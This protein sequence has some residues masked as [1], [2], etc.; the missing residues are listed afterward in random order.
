M[1]RQ[2]QIEKAALTFTCGYCDAAEGEPCRSKT[3]KVRVY[4]H[5]DRWYDGRALLARAES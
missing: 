5:A 3:G 4:V 2:Q 1:S